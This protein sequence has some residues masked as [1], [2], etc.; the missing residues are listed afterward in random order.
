MPARRSLFDFMLE[1]AFNLP[2][3][4]TTTQS[5][6]HSRTRKSSIFFKEICHPKAAEKGPLCA[7]GR[8]P[9]L[10]GSAQLNP[11]SKQAD[12]A[13]VSQRAGTGRNSMSYSTY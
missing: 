1:N 4:K 12:Y 8:G 3:K 10:F 5:L 6:Y 11:K 13:A 2:S 7:I 9:P